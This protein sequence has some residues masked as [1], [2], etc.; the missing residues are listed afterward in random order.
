MYLKM[1]SQHDIFLF[2]T[3]MLLLVGSVAAT[4]Q[5]QVLQFSDLHGY[6]A[7]NASDP[8]WGD[9]ATMLS[10]EQHVLENNDNATTG[11]YSSFVGDACDGTAYSDRTHPKCVE[12]FQLL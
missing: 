8:S 5:L 1:Y 6:V 7:G 9:L 11:V 2:H 10:Y 3:A 12:M 4:K